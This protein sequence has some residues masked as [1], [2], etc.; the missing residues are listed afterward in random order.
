MISKSANSSRPVLAR[1][2]FPF[3]PI[4]TKT[5]SFGN[6]ATSRIRF[7]LSAPQRPL[8]VLIT[9]APGRRISRFSRNGWLTEPTRFPSDANT[10]FKASA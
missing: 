9:S 7:V 3:F 8:S 5:V 2:C 4:V 10:R 6:C 1:N